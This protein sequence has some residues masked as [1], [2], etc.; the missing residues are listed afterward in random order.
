MTRNPFDVIKNSTSKHPEKYYCIGSKNECYVFEEDGAIT[1][2]WSR[3]KDINLETEILR[4]IP[5][6]K[7]DKTKLP[8][9]IAELKKLRFLQI[10]IS[11]LSNENYIL[12]SNLEVLLLI[13]SDKNV[14]SDTV[15]NGIE[16]ISSLKSIIFQN[17]FGSNDCSNNL[18]KFN[19]NNYNLDYLAFDLQKNGNLLK[20]IKTDNSLKTLVISNIGNFNISDYLSK[21]IEEISIITSGNKFEIN[22]F[23]HFSNLKSIFLNGI[24][25]EIDCSIFAKMKNLNTL[26]ILNSKKIKNANAIIQNPFLKN[27]TFINCGKPFKGLTNQF[28]SSK[29]ELLDIKFS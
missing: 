23:V 26:C 20:N 6:A 17:E 5:I 4:L 14:H 25:S 9:F 11:M 12:T 22:S 13:N 3:C 2:P 21:N 24:K 7:T 28:D 27:I 18:S 15:W 19:I 10:P 16:A 29:Y 8:D 1:I